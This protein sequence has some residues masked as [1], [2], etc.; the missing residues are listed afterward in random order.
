LARDGTP[1]NS[2]GAGLEDGLALVPGMLGQ[3]AVLAGLWLVLAEG[4]PGA[5]VPGAVAVSLALLGRRVLGARRPFRIR[6]VQ[7][8][9]FLPY[10]LWQSVRGGTDVALRAVKPAL[11]I[12]PQ[13]H[14]YPLRLAD[15]PARLFFV[16]AVSLLPGTFSACLEGDDIAIHSLDSDPTLIARVRTLE[17]RVAELFG[18]RLSG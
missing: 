12:D 1:R 7:A 18:E 15:G 16:N 5:L 6:P 4:R 13:L 3:T 8:I 17:K 2:S 14:E 11:P 10:F 9:Q